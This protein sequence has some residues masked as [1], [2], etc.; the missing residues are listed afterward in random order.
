MTDAVDPVRTAKASRPE[1]SEVAEWERVKAFLEF[2]ASWEGKSAAVKSQAIFDTFGLSPIRYTQQLLTLIG[3]K[4]AL[5][6]DAPLC[7]RIRERIRTNQ[8]LRQ[9]KPGRT[10]E[11]NK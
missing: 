6:L 9:G 1:W 7:Y 8:Q 3:T 4:V 2:E 10:V 5:E 11:V